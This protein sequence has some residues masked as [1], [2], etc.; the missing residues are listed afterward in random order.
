[1]VRRIDVLVGQ[2][3]LVLAFPFAKVHISGRVRFRK[4]LPPGRYQV[5]DIWNDT[6]VGIL[7]PEQL[8]AGFDAG[9]ISS[10]C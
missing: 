4:P 9:L 2:R 7:T 3:L 5:T 1:M 10:S 6:E 8:A